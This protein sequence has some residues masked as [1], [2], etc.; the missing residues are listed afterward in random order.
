[1]TCCV[2]VS[3]TLAIIIIEADRDD[4]ANIRSPPG[5]HPEGGRWVTESGQ[6]RVAFS[7]HSPSAKPGNLNG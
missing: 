4:A 6:T 3:C 5:I 1:M 2:G 7:L